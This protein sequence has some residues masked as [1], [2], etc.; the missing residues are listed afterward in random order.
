MDHQG[1]LKLSDFGLAT[2]YT[3][4]QRAYSPQVATRWYR[5]PELLFG[6]KEYAYGVDM[7]SIGVIFAELLLH[8]PLFPGQNDLDQ[9]YRIIQVLGHP[10]HVWPQVENLPDYAKVSFPL[11]YTAQP[12]SQ[13]FYGIQKEAMDL[14]SKLLVF[15]PS[16]RL[17]AR[18]ALAHAYFFSETNRIPYSFP[19]LMDAFSSFSYSSKRKNDEGRKKEEFITSLNEPFNF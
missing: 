14:L 11:T 17:T 9:L 10:L 7:W 4:P 5:A 16:K 2:V 19:E 12:F 3:G 1:I 18:E 13:V 8:G 15:D 6:S